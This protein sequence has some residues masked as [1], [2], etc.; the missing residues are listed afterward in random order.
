MLEVTTHQ[1]LSF[2]RKEFW[3]HNSENINKG[4]YN[5]YCYSNEN[6]A[7]NKKNVLKEQTS[8]INLEKPSEELYN[9]IN[10]T[11]K[12]HIHKAEN[13]NITVNVN[14]SP[15]PHKCNQIISE[16]SIFANKKQIEWNPKRIK[17]LQKLNK[18]IIS[19]AFLKEEKIVAHVYLHD[20]NRVVLLHSYH[21]HNFM[22]KNIK[23]YA[24]KYLHWKEILSFKNFGLKLYDFGGI[25]MQQ[26]PGISKFKMS[27]GGEVIDCYSYIEVNPLLSLAINFYKKLG[28]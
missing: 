17:A 25:N 3:F 26:H 11:F 27:F 16:F 7:C 9:Q 23:G 6:D 24:N 4:S 13:L 20:G 12:Y 28:K 10:R 15:T 8:L 19:E 1:F 22:D 18:L 21:S 2:K 14:Y 5:V